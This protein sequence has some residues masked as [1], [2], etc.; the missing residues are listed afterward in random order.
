MACLLIEIYWSVG[1]TILKLYWSVLT[2]IFKTSPKI[3]IRPVC[4]H[5]NRLENCNKD[6]SME[7]NLFDFYLVT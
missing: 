6:S 4:Y 3:I 2:V 5:L 7:T 1:E